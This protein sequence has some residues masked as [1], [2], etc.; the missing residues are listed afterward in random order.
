MVSGAASTLKTAPKESRFKQNSVTKIYHKTKVNQ[1]TSILFWLFKA[2]ASADGKSPT[3][4][5]ITIEGKRAQFSTGKR[6][7]L[8]CGY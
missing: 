2:K 5:R 4:C 3:Y 1:N 7:P 8:P 6:S